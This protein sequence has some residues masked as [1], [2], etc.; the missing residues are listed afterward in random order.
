M[1]HF[2]R[3]DRDTV[4]ANSGG[5]ATDVSVRGISAMRARNDGTHVFGF[6]NMSIEA[7]PSA[8]Q[9]G[10]FRIW[11]HGTIDSRW[12]ARDGRMKLCYQDS[13]ARIQIQGLAGFSD[14]IRISELVY[15]G[16]QTTQFWDYQCA[17]DRLEISGQADTVK[18]RLSM[19]KVGPP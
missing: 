19:D 12:S 2:E 9:A 11:L 5:S 6:E 17:G 8:V 14:P 4:L 3:V 7:E 1:A 13:D 10:T 15:A 18:F 16:G